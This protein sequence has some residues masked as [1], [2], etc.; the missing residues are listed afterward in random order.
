MKYLTD[1][2][3]CLMVIITALYLSATIVM[4]VF[5]G[6]SAKAAKEQTQ[7]LKNQFYAVN[8]PVLIVDV[9]SLKNNL[10]ALRLHNEGS[11]TAF[12]AEIRFEEGFIASLP[13]E[14]FRSH[15]QRESEKT[16]T[17]G[18]GQNY[19]LFF[20]SREYISMPAKKPIVGEIIYQGVNGMTYTDDFEIDIE[21]YLMFHFDEA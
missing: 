14:K 6:K 17:V 5:N 11:Q 12:K 18:V 1:I 20:G 21:S 8:R 7:E 19:D 13:E 2:T 9:V 15:M 16:R 4:C 3:Q 10:L